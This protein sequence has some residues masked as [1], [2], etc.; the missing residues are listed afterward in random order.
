MSDP[1]DDEDDILGESDVEDGDDDDGDDDEPAPPPPPPPSP[2]ISQLILP[3]NRHF[4]SLDNVTDPCFRHLP[5]VCRA[6]PDA[7]MEVESGEE[8]GLLD[9][10]KSWPH[11]NDLLNKLTPDRI[12]VVN[13]KNNKTDEACKQMWFYRMAAK[14]DRNAEGNRIT[15]DE[16]IL[17]QLPK[18]VYVEYFGLLLNHPKLKNSS[19]L[20]LPSTDQNA[21]LLNA[22]N[23]EFSLV[24]APTS[25]LI[26]PP[27]EV[28]EPKK[29]AEPK[30]K[31]DKKPKETKDKPAEAEK[32]P[33]LNTLFK[34]AQPS[35]PM[36]CDRDAADDEKLTD[37]PLDEAAPVNEMPK[38]ARKPKQ[39]PK[40]AAD[41]ATAADAPAKRCKVTRQEM[42]ENLSCEI[43]SGDSQVHIDV[44]NAAKSATISV[45]WHF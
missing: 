12:V 20:N 15:K 34:P 5:G 31:K 25:S 45:V 24:P 27:K 11:G 13:Y 1:D 17:R 44:P 10:G 23:N 36:L 30:E 38:P 6:Y 18:D 41:V 4:Y 32:E 3:Y 33:S 8:M 42:S 29:P 28:K 21:K 9:K 2:P 22:K 19:L 37:P 39:P 16:F 35:S 14:T 7:V 26:T 43:E 40:R